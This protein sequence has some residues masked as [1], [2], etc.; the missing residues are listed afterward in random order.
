MTLRYNYLR[1]RGGFPRVLATD[2]TLSISC[3]LP[4]TIARM[5]CTVPRP[6]DAPG[7]TGNTCLG[8]RVTAPGNASFFRRL[9]RVGRF[10]PSSSEGRQDDFVAAPG[11]S[12]LSKTRNGRAGRDFCSPLKHRWNIRISECI[13][14]SVVAIWGMRARYFGTG[15]PWSFA[16]KPYLQTTWTVAWSSSRP[17]LGRQLVMSSLRVRKKILP[18]NASRWPLPNSNTSKDTVQM[19][20]AT[21]DGCCA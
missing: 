13:A 20:D 3:V 9:S 5:F 4:S 21:Y 7:A 6:C 1:P 12:R 11:V 8:P 14:Q 16:F 2:A 19:Q 10:F 17:R 18:T 15:C